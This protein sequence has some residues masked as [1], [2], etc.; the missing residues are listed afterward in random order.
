M[1]N[2]ATIEARIVSYFRQAPIEDALLVLGIV[3][4]TIKDRE[5]E[6]I[7]AKPKPKRKYTRKAKSEGGVLRQ[8]EERIQERGSGN[9]RS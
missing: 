6:I 9:A 7:P 8:V 1:S 2:R 4:Q 5:E 3:K